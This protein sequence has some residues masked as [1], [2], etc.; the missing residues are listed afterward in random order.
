M[1]Q[2]EW[3]NDHQGAPDA[4]RAGRGGRKGNDDRDERR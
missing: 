2:R 3:W 4:W 1:K